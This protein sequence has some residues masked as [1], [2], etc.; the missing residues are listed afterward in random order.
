MPGQRPP[1]G[2]DVIDEPLEPSPAR[3]DRLPNA[4]IASR[5]RTSSEAGA[6]KT[7][8]ASTGGQPSC[9]RP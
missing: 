1:V 4:A 3:L 6:K 8:S 7:I 9:A 5:S 2:Q